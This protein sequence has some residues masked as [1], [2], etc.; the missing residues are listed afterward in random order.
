MSDASSALAV[1]AS[2]SLSGIQRRSLRHFRLQVED[3]YDACRELSDWEDRN[4]IDEPTPENLAA[5]ERVLNDLDQVGRWLSKTVQEPDFPDADTAKLVDWALQ[6]LKHR[7]ALWHGPL[8]RTQ[9]D[10]ILQTIFDES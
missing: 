6:D 2:I 9:R 8:N 1:E 5:H 10:K 7:R 3:W 4:L